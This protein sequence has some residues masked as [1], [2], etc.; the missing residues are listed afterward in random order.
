MPNRDALAFPSDPL[1]NSSNA[2]QV[3]GVNSNVPSDEANVNF[4]EF[5]RKVTC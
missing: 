5:G 1:F 2:E 4:N 3:A